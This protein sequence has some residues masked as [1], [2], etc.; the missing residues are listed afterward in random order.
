MELG[1][2]PL[3]DIIQQRRLNFLHCILSQGPNSIMLKVFE[4]QQKY[5]T[6]KDWVTSIE[7]DLKEL[8]LKF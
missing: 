7:N 2:L 4:T 8:D 5:K 1:L 3:R 6:K